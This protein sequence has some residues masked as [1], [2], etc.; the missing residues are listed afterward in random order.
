MQENYKP[1]LK[2]NTKIYVNGVLYPRYVVCAANKFDGGLIICGVRHWDKLMCN[3]ADNID[4]SKLQDCIQGFVDQ[5]GLF[6]TRTEAATIARVNKQV[7]KEPIRFND[8]AFSENF[9]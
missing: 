5:Y 6:I 7:L 2:D 3:V 1:C 4:D 9:Y 8:Y